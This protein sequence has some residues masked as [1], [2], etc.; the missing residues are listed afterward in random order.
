MEKFL[1]F[2]EN[3]IK[4]ILYLG[5]LL[6]L[7]YYFFFKGKFDFN[8]IDLNKSKL[9]QD[10]SYL[11]N[12]ALKQFEYMDGMM[13]DTDSLFLDLQ[14]LNSD[15]LKFIYNQFSTHKYKW[16]GSPADALGAMGLGEN[17]DLFGWYRAE[18]SDN[19]LSK[20]RQ[21]WSKTGLSF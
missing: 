8:K 2:I 21:N 20:M 17:L 6:M 1:K 10:E 11:K 19:E 13:T 5:G 14:G 9:S 7:V 12:I 4:A 18:L 3:N 16:F 15:D